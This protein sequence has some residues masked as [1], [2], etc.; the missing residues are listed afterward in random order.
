MDIKITGHEF[1]YDITSMSMLFFPGEKTNYVKRSTAS[2]HI[3]SSLRIK[4][5]KYV[6]KT[7]IKYNS[8][9]YSSIRTREI[10]CDVKNLVKQTFY[11]ACSKATGITS[12]WGI[13]TGI[14]PLSVYMRHLS[15]SSDIKSI[16]KNEYFVSTS[17]ISILDKVYENEYK[18]FNANSHDVSVYISIPF[19]PSKCTYCSFISIS[20]T[21]KNSLLDEYLLNLY[22]EIALKA[23]LIKKYGLKIKSIYVGGGTPGILNNEQI[24]TLFRVI[25]T[26][27]DISKVTEISFE[28]GRPETVTNE[29]LCILRNYG[30]NRICINTQTTNDNVLAS[31]NRKHSYKDYSDAISAVNKIGFN[32][33][34]TDIIAGLPGESYASFCKTVDDVISTGINNITVHTLAIKRAADLSDNESNY[35]PLK[36]SVTRMLEY[37]YD[38]IEQ[39]GYTPYYIYRQKNCV[40]NGEN[41]GFCKNGSECKY[42][43]YMMEDVHSILSCGA[44]ASSKIIDGTKVSRVINVKYPMEYNSVFERIELNTSKLDELLKEIIK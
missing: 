10:D 32:A 29:K 2:T 27:F 31:V 8:V 9:W 7:R 26:E 13:L 22:K 4:D 21:G 40:S 18:Y 19:C 24:E 23:N 1:F 36:F 39:A 35:D 43:V 42:N 33:V 38:K 34:N 15:D 25:N 44:G 5:N 30:V 20:A 12:P 41:I 17:K 6:S 28:L 16:M 14:R 37:A 3:I 11:I